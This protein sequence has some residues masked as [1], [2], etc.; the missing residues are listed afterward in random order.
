MSRKCGPTTNGLNE[1]WTRLSSLVAQKAPMN[2]DTAGRSVE[3]L[4]HHR[5]PRPLTAHLPPATWERRPSALEDFINNPSHHE[6]N[7]REQ[8]RHDS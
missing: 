6:D 2:A 4:E 7:Q 3:L 1:T 5:E 8:L